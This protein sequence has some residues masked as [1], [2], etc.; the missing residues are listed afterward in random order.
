ME[1]RAARPKPVSGRKLVV[2]G[3]AFALAGG[4]FILW[5]FSRWGQDTFTRS[6]RTVEARG[7]AYELAMGITRCVNKGERPDLPPSAG[8]VPSPI[9]R[10]THFDEAQS[11][12]AFDADVFR[13]AG[14]HLRGEVH[15][16]I[17]WRR[18]D[19][20]HGV[21]LARLDEDGDGKADFEAN[22]NVSCDG[23][24]PERCRADKVDE[25]R[26]R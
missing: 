13:C 20:T 25:R 9:A 6:A 1:D 7:R 26:F 4:M 21:A 16:Q 14:F 18:A 3:G 8:P 24:A 23:V 5:A 12:V 11:K 10:S 19:A 22:S 2:I 15:V 17:E